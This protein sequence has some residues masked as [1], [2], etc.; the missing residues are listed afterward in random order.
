MCAGEITVTKSGLYFTENVNSSN[1]RYWSAE[2][3]TSIHGVLL[4]DINFD[5]C[6]VVNATNIVKPLF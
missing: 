3:P 4:H 5:E 2:N 1:N 6:C